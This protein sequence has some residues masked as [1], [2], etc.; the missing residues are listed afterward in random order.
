[1]A[2]SQY[3]DVF[4]R[5]KADQ[6]LE[7]K[8]WYRVKSPDASLGEK[9]AAY[10]VTNI[11]KAKRKMG[12]GIP[13][14]IPTGSPTSNFSVINNKISGI[15]TQSQIKK[16]QEAKKKHTGTTIKL[17]TCQINKLSNEKEGGS[18]RSFRILASTLINALKR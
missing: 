4:N 3:K 17:S 8:A 11:M 12:M 10:A 7:W 1:I 2:Y 16:I 6:I 5:N 14:G 13:T 15:L 9:T 18:L